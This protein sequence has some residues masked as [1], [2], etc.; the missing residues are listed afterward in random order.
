MAIIAV[1]RLK[2]G[3][4]LPPVAA[5][6]LRSLSLS[7]LYSCTLVPDNENY[8]GM[9]QACKDVVSFG[10][11]EKETVQLLL[12]KR[13]R[14]TDGKRLTQEQSG[15]LAQE[16]ISGKKLSESGLQPSFRLSPPQGGFGTR[17]APQP[18]GPVGK[19]PG[20]AALIAKMA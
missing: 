2:G 18:Y 7:R 6:T 3:F 15:K 11:V 14:T 5:S 13:G 17:K 9:L 4:T 12:S 10:P 19:N 8:K 20:I 16:I 1:L